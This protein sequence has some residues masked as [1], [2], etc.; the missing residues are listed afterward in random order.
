MRFKDSHEQMIYLRQASNHGHVELVYAGLDVLGS[1][2]WKINREIFDVVLTVW[3]SGVR[4]CK[5]PP[6]TYDVPEPVKPSEEAL[7][8]VKTKSVYSQRLKAWT[9][10][11]A[12]NH[13]DRCNINYKLEIARSVSISP[14][15]LGCV[16]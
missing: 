16:S 3:N 14:F 2:P 9:H 15:L 5:I 12:N 7:R 13:S 4:L 1:T 8:E 6:A 10:A 11:K